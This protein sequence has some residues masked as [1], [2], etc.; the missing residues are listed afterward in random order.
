MKRQTKKLTNKEIAPVTLWSKGRF[1]TCD[2]LSVL[3]PGYSHRGLNL[4]QRTQIDCLS[5]AS[6]RQSVC[7]LL[8]LMV[9]LFQGVS[10]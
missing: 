1:F 5:Q 8:R 10:Q 7:L 2:S 4:V 6:Y 3:S 9:H